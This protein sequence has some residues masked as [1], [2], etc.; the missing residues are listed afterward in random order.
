[1]PIS[2]PYLKPHA[3]TGKA[4]SFPKALH[5]HNY[6]FCGLPWRQ[7]ILSVLPPFLS[8]HLLD[9]GDRKALPLGTQADWLAVEEQW[10]GSKKEMERKEEK[11]TQTHTLG[12]SLVPS[13][14][15]FPLPA[16]TLFN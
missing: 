5:T 15:A 7:K 16:L 6:I 12:C 13:S 9:L 4:K 14:P 10:R 11:H 2:L 3:Y 8:L 1:M